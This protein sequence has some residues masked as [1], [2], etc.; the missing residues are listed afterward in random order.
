MLRGTLIF[1]KTIEV[2]ELLLD[3]V[4]FTLVI[5][6]AASRNNWNF[7]LSQVGQHLFVICKYLN[8]VRQDLRK[9]QVSDVAS[10]G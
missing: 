9:L 10:E 8:R 4:A 7:G 5:A 3:Q 1:V 6:V 2:D